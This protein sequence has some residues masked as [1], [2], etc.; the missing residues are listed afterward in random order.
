MIHHVHGPHV[1]ARTDMLDQTAASARLELDAGSL[2]D[3]HDRNLSLLKQS[4]L[5]RICQPLLWIT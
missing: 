3:R 5:R 1:H 2:V 4:G